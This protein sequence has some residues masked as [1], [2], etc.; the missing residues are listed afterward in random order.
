VPKIALLSASVQLE[1]K[2]TWLGL[3]APKVSAIILRALKM[4]S[5]PFIES[6]CPLLPAFADRNLIVLTTA[7]VTAEILKPLVAA[8][9]K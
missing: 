5:A 1:V 7:S 9:S 6:L 8:L 3:V 2:I 4:S